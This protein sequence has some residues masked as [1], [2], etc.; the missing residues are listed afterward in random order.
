VQVKQEPEDAA[1]PPPPPQPQPDV[2]FLEKDVY[3]APG[4]VSSPSKR[5]YMSALGL[6]DPP[7]SELIQQRWQYEVAQQAGFTSGR[8]GRP[9]GSGRGRGGS[10]RGVGG[11]G[12]GGRKGYYSMHD[13]PEDVDD[14]D[15]QCYKCSK[16]SPL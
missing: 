9:R 8:R 11:R 14:H 1:S 2:F 10:S 4:D 7:T 6:T 15:D 13:A 3:Y 12:R 16:V 5:T